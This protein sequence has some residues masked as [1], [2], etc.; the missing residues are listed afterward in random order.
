MLNRSARTKLV[1]FVLVALVATSYLGAS[2]AGLDLFRHGYRVTAELPDAGGLFENGEVTYRGVPVGKV[3]SLSV[4][5]RGVTATLEIS[6]DAPPLPADAT[7]SVADRS[8]IGEQYLDLSG[9]STSGPHLRAGDRLTTGADTTMPPD[10]NGLLSD[11]ADFTGSVPSDDL[12]TVIDEGYD[13]ASGPTA[14]N[15]RRLLST[16]QT[17]EQQ[18]DTNYLGTAALIRNSRRVLQTQE[19]SATSIRSYSRDLSTIADTLKSS[20]GDLR[21]LLSRT[22]GSARQVTGLVHDVGTP[23][24]LLMNNLVPTA[25]TFGK[26]APAIRDA[27]VRAPQAVSVGYSVSGPYGMNLGMMTSFF[28]PWPC[29]SGYGGTTMRT[30]LD[31]AASTTRPLNLNAVCT[32]PTRNRMGPTAVFGDTTAKSATRTTTATTLADLMGGQQ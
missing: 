16:S 25:V 18:A 9:T 14:T 28:N 21:T 15:L 32:D 26:D 12:N 22:P 17:F 13:I 3:S 31:T 27:L 1:V 19:E 20:D 4:E 8:A 2:Y 23:L 10:I 6:A 5:E 11:A 7:V 24:S 30:G 29:T